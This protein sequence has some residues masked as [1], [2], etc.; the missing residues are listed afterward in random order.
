MTAHEELQHDGFS[1]L[2]DLRDGESWA[3]HLARLEAERQG[4]DLG[5]GRVRGTFLVAELDGALVARVSLRHE[6]DEALSR[7]GG[8]VGYGVRPAFRRRGIATEVLRRSLP[9]LREVGVARVLVTC[10]DDNVGSAKTIERC[11]G[12][13]EGTALDDRQVLHRRYWIG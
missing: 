1:F 4:R 6:L 5:P 7:I 13:L 3:D 11:G 12:L 2:L 10:A 9:L 8:H